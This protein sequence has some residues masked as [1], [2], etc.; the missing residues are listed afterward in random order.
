MI[1]E[2]EFKSDIILYILYFKFFMK[3]V[4]YRYYQKGYIGMIINIMFNIVLK[5]ALLS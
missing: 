1:L 5:F 2:L 3:K 4:K